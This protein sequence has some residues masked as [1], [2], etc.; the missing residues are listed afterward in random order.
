MEQR[1]YILNK[2]QRVEKEKIDSNIQ[3]NEIRITALG[4]RKNYISYA[5]NL[6]NEDNEHA[7]SII[8]LKAMG[9]AITKTVAIC[10]IIKR[11]ISGLHQL[12]ELDSSEIVDIWEPLEE[13]LQLVKVVRRVSSITISLSKNEL[14]VNAAGYQPPIPEE[15]VKPERK[16]LVDAPRSRGKGGRGR[17]RGRGRGRGRGGGGGRGRGRG[18]GNGREPHMERD[19]RGH[20]GMGYQQERGHQ[21]RRRQDRGRQDRG[22]QDHGFQDQGFQDRGHQDRGH[23][24]RGY[25]A[26]D[27]YGNTDYGHNKSNRGGHYDSGPRNNI[28]RR[29]RGRGRGRQNQM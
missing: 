7:E 21:D 28:R 6:L 5:L 24:D 8:F 16:D 4:R 22:R 17:R 9:R 14:D 10:E 2:Y 29:G 13:G 20:Q 12:T 27:N 19:D 18:R 11:R 1:D 15:E 25:N 3:P 26:Y 23:Q